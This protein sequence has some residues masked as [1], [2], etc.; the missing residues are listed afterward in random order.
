[1]PSPI[2]TLLRVQASPLPTQMVLGACGSMA[3]APMDCTDCLSKTGLYVVPPFTDFQTPPLAAPT[4]TVRRPSSLTPV[5]AETRPLMVAE[6]ILRAPSPETVSESKTTSCACAYV[7]VLAT[8]RRSDA[9]NQGNFS[10]LIFCV[11]AL[12]GKL[13]TPKTA[14]QI[15]NTRFIL[16]RPRISLPAWKQA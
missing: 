12:Q 4:Y 15:P 1:M 3:M 10:L 13:I 14:W 9:A 11:L 16:R 8:R 2:E 6:P 5:T 7:A